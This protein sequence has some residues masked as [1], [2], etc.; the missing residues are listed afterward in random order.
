MVILVSPAH[1]LAN[2]LSL[3]FSLE[4]SKKLIVELEFLK[5]E[6]KFKDEQVDLLLNLNNEFELETKLLFEKSDILEKK[7]NL[8]D[9]NFLIVKDQKENWE[10]EAKKIN[11]KLIK[12][13]QVPWYKRNT[14]WFVVGL[15]LG[16]YSGK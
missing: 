15:T 13:K 6:N 2:D 10:I 16:V 14:L 11:K 4:T 12:A 3:G 8:L 5:E 7:Y 9:E 1:L